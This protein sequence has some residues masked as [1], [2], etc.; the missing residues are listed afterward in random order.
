MAD[1]IPDYRLM[2]A[3]IHRQLSVAFNFF[4]LCISTVLADGLVMPE[5]PALELPV[6]GAYQLRIL[7]PSILELTLITAKAPDPAPV[8]RWDFVGTN[9]QLRLPDAKQF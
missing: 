5:E 4:V 8:E 1:S 3:P 6:P 2:H 9:G 7:S